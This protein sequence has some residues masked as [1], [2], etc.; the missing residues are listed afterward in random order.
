MLRERGMET[1][2]TTNIHLT[3]G[4]EN[5]PGAAF[6]TKMFVTTLDQKRIQLCYPPMNENKFVSGRNL[7]PEVSGEIINRTFQIPDGTK[8]IVVGHR[9]TAGNHVTNIRKL[10]IEVDHHA[11]YQRLKLNGSGHDRA[12]VP[13]MALEGRFYV[14]PMEDVIELIHPINQPTFFKPFDVFEPLEELHPGSPKP[15]VE[16]K[17]VTIE[18]E[19]KQVKFS[20]PKRALRL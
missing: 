13:A 15:V 11:P 1:K 20:R 18:G 17:T 19:Q 5:I 6:S 7:R 12:V 4:D 16:T 9:K 14:T 3:S 8:L 10:M 2:Q